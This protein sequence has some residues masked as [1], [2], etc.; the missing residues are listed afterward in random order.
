MNNWFTTKQSA[1]IKLM[2]TLNQI[3]HLLLLLQLVLLSPLVQGQCAKPTEEVIE[4]LLL[5]HI[6]ED[7]GET[8][9]LELTQYTISCLSSGGIRDMYNM[10]SIIVAFQSNVT[11]DT[12][13]PSPTGC[14]GFFHIVCADNSPTWILDEISP[15]TRLELSDEADI[16]IEE[17]RT[18]CGACTYL[19]LFPP[20]FND[21]YDAETHCYGKKDTLN[22]YV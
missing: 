9:D 18:D 11:I 13:P 10:A 17:P 22:M 1:G 4:D 12:C 16:N 6:M 14:I 21:I 3:F 19:G 20:D 2:A 8:V 7:A 5:A 15:S